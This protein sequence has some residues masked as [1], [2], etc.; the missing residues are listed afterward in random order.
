MPPRP[1]RADPHAHRRFRAEVS[2]GV[3]EKNGEVVA[4]LR[5]AAKRG[6]LKGFWRQRLQFLLEEP[7]VRT[8]AVASTYA[9]I[10]DHDQAL[11]WL[12]KL[13]A[14]HGAWIRTLKTNA[15]W[16]PLRADPRFQDPLRRTNVA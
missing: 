15:V 4:A 12:E 3:S 2:G 11:A 6:G 9:R 10:G 8:H 5:A 14:E 7:H 16:D 1:R 13:Y